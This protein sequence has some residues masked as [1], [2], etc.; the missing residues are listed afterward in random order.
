MVDDVT[1]IRLRMFANGYL[2][3]PNRGKRPVN[4]GWP[5]VKIT[6]RLIRRWAA[7][8][9]PSTGMIIRGGPA[10]MDLDINHKAMV[11][12]LAEETKKIAPHLFDD[13]LVR[14]SSGA[15]EMWLAA[16]EGPL[17]T[18][19]ASRLWVPVGTSPNDEDAP[20]YRVEIFGGDSVRQFGVFGPHSFD[21]DG[22]V[23]ATYDWDGNQSPATVPFAALPKL[24]LRQF[25]DI[26]NAFDHIAEAEGLMIRARAQRAGESLVQYTLEMSTVLELED[27][28]T[29]TLEDAVNELP[30]RDE[31]IYFRCSGAFH[32]PSRR[33]RDSHSVWIGRRGPTVYD[34]MEGIQY[35]LRERRPPDP[36]SIG[37]DIEEALI[38]QR[39]EAAVSPSEAPSEDAA[40][41]PEEPK[42][43][44]ARSFE[45]IEIVDD[46]EETFRN[47]IAFLLEEFAWDSKALKGN[48]IARPIYGG[49]APITIKSLKIV[50]APFNMTIVGPRGGQRIVSPVDAWLVSNLKIVIEGVRLRPALPRPLCLEDGYQFLNSYHPPELPTVGGS[51][52][53]FLWW[54]E[55]LLPDPEER[56]W[57]LQ[58]LAWKVQHPEQRLVAPVM[59]A[60]KFGTG[61]GLMSQVL[62]LLFG[63]EHCEMTNFAVITGGAGSRFNVEFANLVMAFVN[64]SHDTEAAWR[65]NAAAY[66][67][68]KNFIEPNGNLQVRIEAKGR[69]PYY[70]KLCVST[71]IFTN[72]KDFLKIPLNERRLQILQNGPAATADEVST[73]RRWMADAR[74]IGAL[75]RHLAALPVAIDPY[76]STHT[77]G[78]EIVRQATETES[79]VAYWE[80]IQRIE[81]VAEIFT[82]SQLVSIACRWAGT[83][84]FV[85]GVATASN[86]KFEDQLRMLTRKNAYRIGVRRGP[87]DHP[88]YAGMREHVF[89]LNARLQAF[90]SDASS[91]AI[92]VELDKVQAIISASDAS[93]AAAFS[94][95]PGAEQAGE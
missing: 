11:E 28:R 57:F 4:Q 83:S 10:A 20:T 14:Y 93:F 78:L 23:L 50:M 67:N 68:L 36:Y 26:C 39:I 63:L 13:A 66:E 30:H 86:Q 24:T 12:A 41:P 69:D 76:R 33:R 62:S 43:R 25:G 94:T 72:N 45:A 59:L 51:P 87:N 55:R 53:G 6:E 8:D 32:D 56:E 40:E 29:V 22:N 75:Y 38:K 5:K 34:F 46:Q 52:D 42:A 9:A 89:A 81:V 3:L 61:R 18:R 48:G 80:A 47:G 31:G 65:V 64:E 44:R 17:F 21:D 73:F 37:K 58:W 79:E 84:R 85:G 60:V 95:I 71:L 16:V 54:I 91:A 19:L 82:R 70:D 74:N 77:A 92:K 2:P 7:L 35:C 49:A 27:G 88:M 15:K 1:D 90:W